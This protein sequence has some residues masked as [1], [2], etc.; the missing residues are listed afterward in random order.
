MI[1]KEIGKKIRKRNK[2]NT[3]REKK[4]MNQYFM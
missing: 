2:K 4:K 1:T 3:E